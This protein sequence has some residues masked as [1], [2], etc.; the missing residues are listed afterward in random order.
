MSEQLRSG[1]PLSGMGYVKF[2]GFRELVGYLV[3]FVIGYDQQIEPEKQYD[4]ELAEEKRN[5]MNIVNLQ[6]INNNTKR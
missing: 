6:N 3:C 4:Y 2:E 5:R 1:K